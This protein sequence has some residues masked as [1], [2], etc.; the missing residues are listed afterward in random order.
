MFRSTVQL[1][2][3]SATAASSA[4]HA[5]NGYPWSIRDSNVMFRPT[6]QVK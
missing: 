3:Q 6:S 1:H 4:T 2:H 5:V